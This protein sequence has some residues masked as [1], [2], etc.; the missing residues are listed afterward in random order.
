MNNKDMVKVIEEIA[1]EIGFE[2]IDISMALPKGIIKEIREHDK[3]TKAMGFWMVELLSKHLSEVN[4]QEVVMKSP[5]RM[6]H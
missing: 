6:E 3:T 1:E 2:F 4:V 5:S